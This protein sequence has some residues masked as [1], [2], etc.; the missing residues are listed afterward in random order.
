VDLRLNDPDQKNEDGLQLLAD[1]DKANLNTK[2]IIFTAYGKERHKQIASESQKFHGFIHKMKFDV[3]EFCN[4]VRQ[5]VGRVEVSSK[6]KVSI[7]EPT[8]D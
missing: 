3:A 1:I 8:G 2:V 7:D 6:D 4:L 5:A